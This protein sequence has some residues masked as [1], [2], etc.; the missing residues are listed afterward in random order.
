MN[1]DIEQEIADL[2]LADEVAEQMAE[3]EALQEPAFVPGIGVV[4]TLAAGFLASIRDPESRCECRD[5]YT[6]HVQPYCRCSVTKW[7]WL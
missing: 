7:N 1:D 2:G 6:V 3:F 5:G 4:S